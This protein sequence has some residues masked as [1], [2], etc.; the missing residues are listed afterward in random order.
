MNQFL[1]VLDVR[2]FSA[3]KVIAWMM[4]TFV[5]IAHFMSHGLITTEGSLLWYNILCSECEF[6]SKFSF[7]SV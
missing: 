1:M 7:P 6:K 5:C 4:Y 2:F 3:I